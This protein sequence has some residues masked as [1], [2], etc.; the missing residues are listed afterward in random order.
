MLSVKTWGEV[1]PLEP[2]AVT[3]SL[4]MI[5]R[6]EEATIGRCLE[7]AKDLVDEIVVVDTGSLDRTKEIARRYTDKVYDFAWIDD[8]AAARNYVFS[9]ATQEYVL[10]LDGDDVILPADR[11]RFLALKA[12]LD[13][14]VDSWTM[15]Y[16]LAHDENGNVTYSIRHHRLLKRSKGFRWVGAV[17]EYLAVSGAIADSDVAI[18]HGKVRPATERNLRI[19]DKRLA[20]GEDFSPRDLYYY[21]NELADHGRPGEAMTYYLRFLAT[22]AGWLEDNIAA[23]GRL[24]DC[25]L[26]L[27]DVEQHLACLYKTFSYDTPRA[28]IC[29]RLGYHFLQLNLLKQAAFWYELA[30]R[31][32]LPA[33]SLGAISHACW[34]WLP[35]LQL[36]VCYDRMGNHALACEHNERAASYAPENPHVLYNRKYFEGLPK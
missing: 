10:H 1:V 25:C 16:N 19:Y 18:T 31:L 17:H 30:T 27:G 32:E 23:C 33:G 21:A 7:S 22:K 20:A 26:A 6:D 35:H 2:D 12:S 13:R 29:C 11:E 5:V 24:A 14:R 34:T 36:C 28:E 9:L 15:P 8:F 4:C 3:V